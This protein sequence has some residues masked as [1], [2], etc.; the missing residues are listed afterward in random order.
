MSPG[1]GAAL[2]LPCRGCVP[3]GGDSLQVP[4]GFYTCRLD[5]VWWV[6]GWPGMHL[7][8]LPVWVGSLRVLKV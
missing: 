5:A 8:F 6:P 1:L 3:V 2:T 7:A 4:G